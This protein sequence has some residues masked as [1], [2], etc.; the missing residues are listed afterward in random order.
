M[1]KVAQAWNLVWIHF[2]RSILLFRGNKGF[3]PLMLKMN[4]IKKLNIFR[5]RALGHFVERL[6][7]FLLLQ[8]LTF[9][10]LTYSKRVV[11]EFKFVWNILIKHHCL[12]TKKQKQITLFNRFQ[13]LDAYYIFQSNE[14]YTLLLELKHA[15]FTTCKSITS[16]SFSTTSTYHRGGDF[17]SKKTVFF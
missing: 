6:N 14:N 5:C 7:A 11:K 12:G 9:Y 10:I 15:S 8:K 13:R 2:I 1:Y 4:K 3:L 16:I 17:F